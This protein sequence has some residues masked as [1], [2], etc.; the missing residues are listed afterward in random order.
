MS[1]D[2]VKCSVCGGQMRMVRVV[3]EKLGRLKRYK[4]TCGHC[5]DLRD[6]STSQDASDEPLMLDGFQEMF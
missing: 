5:E 3:T 1:S 2:S 6:V 4:C